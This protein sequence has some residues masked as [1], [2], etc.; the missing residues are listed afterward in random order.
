MRVEG[1]LQ[2][3]YGFISSDLPPGAGP[4]LS[5]AST[6]GFVVTGTGATV[7]G[8]PPV[9]GI[10]VGPGHVPPGVVVIPVLPACASDFPNWTTSTTGGGTFTSDVGI[11]RFEFADSL[12][13]GGVNDSIQTG[14]ACTTI[15]GDAIAGVITVNGLI[16]EQN[17]G[18]DSIEVSVNGAVV[19]FIESEGNTGGCTMV[20]RSGSASIPA[21]PDQII[22]VSITSGDGAFHVGAYWEVTIA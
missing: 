1:E 19:V 18:Y 9:A 6:P 8:A 2:R 5:I 4:I 21:G 11:L 17:A 3:R 15:D 13:C 22:E 14:T 16:E 7:V 20:P 12:N 10:P